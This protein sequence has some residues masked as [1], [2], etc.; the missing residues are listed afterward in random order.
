MNSEFGEKWEVSKQMFS[1]LSCTEYKFRKYFKFIS[2]L[3]NKCLHII[4]LNVRCDVFTFSFKNKSIE[5]FLTLH[6]AMLYSEQALNKYL[7]K[8]S[9]ASLH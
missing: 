9:L 3:N 2:I 4:I 6:R 7:G 8:E 5:G 1:T